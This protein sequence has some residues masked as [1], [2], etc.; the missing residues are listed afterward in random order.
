VSGLLVTLVL[1]GW[2][3]LEGYRA[4]LG[5][6][7]QAP[8]PIRT[9]AECLQRVQASTGS[10]EGILIDM[11]EGIWHPLYYYFRRVQPLT[12]ATAPLDPAVGQAIL[13]ASRPRPVLMSSAV[14]REFDERMRETRQPGGTAL[15]PPMLTFLNSVLLLPGPYAACSSEAPVRAAS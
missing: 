8:H 5:R 6:L 4:Q 1:L 3:P 11:P 9:A 7:Q 13:D 15:S 10:R 14:W 12:H 2:M